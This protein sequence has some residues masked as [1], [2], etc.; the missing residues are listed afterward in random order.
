MPVCT[1]IHASQVY[2]GRHSGVLLR[3]SFGGS[4][5]KTAVPMEQE[6]LFFDDGMQLLRPFHYPETAFD[7]IRLDPTSN[8]QHIVEMA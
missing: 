5:E 1:Q 4:Q 8:L 6:I 7:V 3:T 2:P